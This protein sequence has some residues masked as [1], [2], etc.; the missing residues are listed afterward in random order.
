M[1][2][3]AISSSDSAVWCSRGQCWSV[4]VS[5]VLHGRWPWD[6]SE[7]ATGHIARAQKMFST[8]TS[9]KRHHMLWNCFQGEGR[10]PGTQ[11][12][13]KSHRNLWRFKKKK[14]PVF[15]FSSKSG[16][17]YF[18]TRQNQ[19][20]TSKKE[21]ETHAYTHKPHSETYDTQQI[22]KQKQ[23]KAPDS[24]QTPNT[25]IS[26]CIFKKKKNLQKLCILATGHLGWTFFNVLLWHQE[27]S[28]YTWVYFLPWNSLTLSHFS[29]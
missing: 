21:K 28:K 12:Q 16:A 23:P 2:L 19:T 14:G 3:A 22:N 29:K 17:F 1:A 15:Q 27:S 9:V 10:E 20:K 26:Q 4:P 13:Y 25:H 24:R 11:M 6:S 8:D 18:L 5:A 7:L